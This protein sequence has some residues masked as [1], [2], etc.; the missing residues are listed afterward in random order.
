MKL[1]LLLLPV[2]FI[3]FTIVYYIAQKKDNNGLV[4]IAWGFGF[5]LIALI[6]MTYSNFAYSSIL[7][8]ILVALWGLR[9]SY[10]LYLRNWNKKEDF[11]YQDMRKRWGKN[12]KLKAFTRV[13]YVSNDINATSIN[14]NNS[15]FFYGKYYNL[16]YLYRTIYLDYRVLL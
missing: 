10:H 15:N 4:D 7:L 13:L 3:Y 2:M 16:H 11:R 14:N 8:F 9:L 12:H 5:V 1:I 6:S